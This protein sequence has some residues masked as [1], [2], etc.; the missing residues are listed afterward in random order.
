MTLS[1]SAEVKVAAP[2]GFVFACARDLHRA[3]ARA[4]AAGAKLGRVAPDPAAGERIAWQVVPPGR[5][6]RLWRFRAA[7]LRERPGREM[8]FAFAHAD[9]AGDLAVTFAPEG[10]GAC[11]LRLDLSVR[12]LTLRAR[13]LAPSARLSRGR[14]AAAIARR[15]TRRAGEI[16]A[17]WRTQRVDAA[18]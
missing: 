3:E 9:V 1:L 7:L 11:C 12:A 8:V 2:S 14:I 16:E 10:P 15:L 18:G 4:R 13:L 17:L 5:R 6:G